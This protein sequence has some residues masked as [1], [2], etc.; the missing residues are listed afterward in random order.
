MLG[1]EQN[2]KN[3]V[4]N[5][6]IKI[7]DLKT[8]GENYENLEYTITD[9][10]EQNN[11]FNGTLNRTLQTFNT[12]KKDIEIIIP[13][14]NNILNNIKKQIED[15][16]ELEKIKKD[17]KDFKGE[18]K[19]IQ[20]NYKDVISEINK[21]IDK[22]N[23]TNIA[24]F[25]F[26]NELLKDVDDL[27]IKQE[28][29]KKLEENVETFKKDVNTN[30]ENFKKRQEELQLKQKVFNFQIQEQKNPLIITLEKMKMQE[31]P[32]T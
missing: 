7:E 23:K 3:D 20:E 5:L 8:L 31:T 6:N 4:N 25:E 12:F 28:D 17:I 19:E 10:I 22:N 11:D 32:Y 13:Q 18:S 1:F 16:A 30:T 14:L 21:F 9:L 27:D 24:I 29:L 26:I 15:F 2:L